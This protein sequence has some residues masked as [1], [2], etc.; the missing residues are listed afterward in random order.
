MERKGREKDEQREEK[1]GEG[2]KEQQVTVSPFAN[3]L[4]VVVFAILCAILLGQPYILSFSSL[5][6][7]RRARRRKTSGR[8]DQSPFS[9]S[10]CISSS[11]S[12][13]G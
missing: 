6:W 9:A 4:F 10:P 11:S 13:A 12:F 8:L 1:A 3:K 7:S 5:K 2:E